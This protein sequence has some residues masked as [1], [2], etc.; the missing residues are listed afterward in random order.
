MFVCWTATAELSVWHQLGWDEPA[1]ILDLY[2]EE[3]VLNNGRYKGKG[4]FGVL[5]T[6][7]RYGID[8]IGADEKDKNREL[9][10]EGSH[11]LNTEGR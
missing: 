7:R 10:I 2:C 11:S 4:Q 1:V 6:C 5:E 9:A 8:G 3:R